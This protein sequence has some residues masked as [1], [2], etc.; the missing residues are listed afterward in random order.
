MGPVRS[1]TQIHPSL[2]LGNWEDTFPWIRNK[3]FNLFNGVSKIAATMVGFAIFDSISFSPSSVTTNDPYP[4]EGRG[5]VGT[6]AY[7]SRQEFWAT[8]RQI[9]GSI[10]L[11]R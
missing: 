5:D 10:H 3:R 1:A 8:A 4:Q 2:S 9:Y 11:Q 6:T 7:K